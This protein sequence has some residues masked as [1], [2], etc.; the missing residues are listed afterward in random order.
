MKI[1]MM[2]AIKTLLEGDG[3]V[4]L[5]QCLGC[6]TRPKIHFPQRCQ[7]ILQTQM[8]RWG[9]LQISACSKTIN[10]QMIRTSARSVPVTLVSHQLRSPSMNLTSSAEGQL[11][12]ADNSTGQSG[13]TNTKRSKS[14]F[15]S[16]RCAS[17][18]PLSIL[19]KSG[20]L[21]FG[22]GNPP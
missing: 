4:S 1:H 6:R 10:L 17:D 5:L 9:Y 3:P 20:T 15:R 19:Q 2:L 22:Q 14:T 7:S 16:M 11:D 13:R 18:M 8:S 21:N 12:N